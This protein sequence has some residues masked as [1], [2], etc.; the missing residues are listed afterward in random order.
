MATPNIVPRAD[1]EG[2]LGTASKYWASA[3]IDN[4]FVSKIGRDADNLLSFSTDNQIIFRV[5]AADK[6]LLTSARLAPNA[7]D[8]AA[9][10]STSLGWSDLFLASGATINFDNGNVTLTHSSGQLLMPDNHKLRFGNSG[11]L[12]L[13]HNTDSYIE[14]GSAGNLIFQQ[15]VDDADIIF[16]CDDG[17]GGT[18]AY[19]TLDG[20]VNQI[21]IAKETIFADAILASFGADRDLRIQHS[22][23]NSFIDNYTGTLNFRQRVDDGD[24][25]FSCDDGS[26]GDTEYFRIDGGASAMVASKSIYMT[27]NKRFYAGGGGDLGIYHDGSNNYIDSADG[28]PGYLYIRNTKTDGD[29]YFVSDNGAG[30]EA[31]YFYLDGSSATHDGS[32][33][34][35]LYTNWPDNSRISLG[36]SHDFRFHHNSSHSYIENL[37]GNL[38]IINYSNDSDIVFKSDDGSGGVATYFKLSG[39]TSKTIFSKTLNLQDSVSLYLG[40]GNDLQL[41]HNSANSSIVNSTGHLYITNAADDSDVVLQCDDGSGGV[42]PYLILDGDDVKTNVFKTMEFQDNVKLAIGNSEDLVID[43]NATNSR[44]TNYTGD[45]VILNS[46]DDKDIIFQSD[47]GSGGVETYMTI[48][49]GNTQVQFAK[50]TN[51]VDGINASFGSSGDLKIS[52]SGTNSSIENETGHLYII[53]DANDSDIV[54]QCDDASGGTTE[55][56]RVDGGENRIVYSVDGRYLDNI[57]SLYGSGGD[58]QILHSGTLATIQNNTG[59]LQISNHQDDGDIEFKCDDGSGSI[60]TY[61]TLDGGLG[62]TTV[63]KAMRFNDGVGVQFGTGSDFSISHNGTD[64]NIANFTGNLNITANSGDMNITNNNDDGDII[65]KSDDG[66]G[67][68]TTYFFLDGSQS[69]TSF[70]KDVIFADSKKAL[71]GGSGDLAMHHDGSN[72]YIS[73]GGTGDL[74]IQQNTNDKDLVLQCDDGSGGSTTYLQLDGSDVST[75]I[76]TQKVI[77]SNLPTSDPG[78]TGQLWNDNGTLKISA[79]G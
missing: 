30:G 41:L 61:I 48:D 52:H 33:T 29:I 28:S 79:G 51:Y 65:F 17:S 23:S 6:L 5:N 68:I 14:K 21:H 70:Q 39:V 9:L 71:F 18:T 37:T 11:D 43:H 7:N 49:G 50:N 69:N 59:D 45:L 42:T 57:K 20:G 15:N 22:G 13:Y 32:A 77:M 35:A 12:T 10:G 36:A 75:K 34:T 19:I 24:M 8:G 67:G 38:E 47:D 74:Y 1:S 25:I 66:S 2:G 31:T 3:Y 64:S 4:V 62:Y 63:Q 58:L 54:F 16:Q 55:Y 44:I 73:Q 40:T 27:D 46:A 76:L 53:N 26:G 60:A 56:F 78:T 72:S